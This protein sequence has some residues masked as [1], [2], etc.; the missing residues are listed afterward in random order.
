MEVCDPDVLR[1]IA[2]TYHDLLTHEK[3]FDFLIDLL[4]K[5]EL[6]D[7]LSLNA[8]DKTISYSMNTSIKP[9]NDQSPFAVLVKRL[10]ESNEQMRAQVGKINHLVL[11]DDDKNRS[12]ILDANSI[13][14]IESSIRNL[15]RLT[16]T[17]HEIC[18]DLTTQILLLSDANE[19][20][21]KNE[22]SGPYESLC[23]CR[24][25]SFYIHT[26]TRPLI[27]LNCASLLFAPHNI[28]HVELIEQ[29]E[30]VD[31]FKE[32]NLWNKPLITYP[33]GYVDEQPWSLL[34]SDNFYSISSIRLEDQQTDALV[35]LPPEYQSAMNK[36]QKSISSL[37]NER[38]AAQLN[39]KQRQCFQRFIVLNFEA[40]IDATGNTKILNHLSS[41]QQ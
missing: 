31:L 22:D 20:S 5:D 26:P 41:L 25:S 37:S 13:S 34:P 24:S 30:R 9:G 14:S 2:S 23:Q 33:A 3:S 15:D 11:K 18:S 7:S 40:W 29:M 12:L 16:K 35:P 28:S 17:F 19:R 39:L 38:T 6:H 32:L 4:E 1:H 27:Q 21:I 36:R 10:I 8:L